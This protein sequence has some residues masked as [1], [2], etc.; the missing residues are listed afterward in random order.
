MKREIR[1]QME[2]IK[3]ECYKL[4]QIAPFEKFKIEY[5]KNKR[6]N[7]RGKINLVEIHSFYSS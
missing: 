6:I 1:E 5:N 7:D 2:V 4:S 3:S